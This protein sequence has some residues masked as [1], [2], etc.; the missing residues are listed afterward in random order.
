LRRVYVLLDFWFDWK[1]YNPQ[2]SV[3]K[4]GVAK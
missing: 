2:T 1:T 4:L 3:Y